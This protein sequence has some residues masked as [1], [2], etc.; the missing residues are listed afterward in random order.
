M[1]F[2][3]LLSMSAPGSEGC[4]WKM[5]ALIESVAIG[6]NFRRYFR[7]KYLQCI[8]Q[9]NTHTEYSLRWLSG[10]GL[11]KV[12][13]ELL[14]S[15]AILPLQSMNYDIQFSRILCLCYRQGRAQREGQNEALQWK[16]Y[17][18]QQEKG[19]PR[20]KKK[21]TPESLGWISFP[22][23]RLHF[24]L[25]EWLTPGCMYDYMLLK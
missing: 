22:M 2:S 4:K 18:P 7:R 17:L 19:R 12:N 24:H 21:T 14:S 10:S 8:Q 20:E 25:K 9:Y 13:I 3:G 23:K 1:A 5:V 16:A 6:G 15:W 11:L